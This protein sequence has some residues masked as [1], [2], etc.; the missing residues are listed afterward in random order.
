VLG[1]CE[2]IAARCM[3]FEP[4]AKKMTR[5]AW[6]RALLSA[7]RLCQAGGLEKLRGKLHSFANGPQFNQLFRDKSRNLPRRREHG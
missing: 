7:S 1:D 5:A 4:P 3:V 6:R 2:H